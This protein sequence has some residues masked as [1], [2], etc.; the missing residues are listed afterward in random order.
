MTQR[1]RREY[2][3]QYYQNNSAYFKERARKREQE[4]KE[5]FQ[6]QKVG[7]VCKCCGIADVRV[8]DFHHLDGSNKEGQYDTIIKG[9]WS[10][11]RILR[12]LA[13]CEVLCA[14]CH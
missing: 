11:E 6:Q 12:E 14:N 4:I 8:L 9:G 13:K 5:F 10:N 1:D 2:N 7:L 3:R